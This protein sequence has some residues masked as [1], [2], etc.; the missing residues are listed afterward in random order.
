MKKLFLLLITLLFTM[1]VY[2]QSGTI[3]LSNDAQ[4]AGRGGTSIGVFN[5]YELMMSNP[6]GLSFVKN[7]TLDLN[8]SVMRS[9]TY[10]KNTLNDT[11]GKTDYN[12]L[13]DLGYVHASKNNSKWA[14]GIGAFTQGGMGADFSLNNALYV[15]AQGNYVKQTYHSK[16][17]MMEFGP[18]VAYK[19]SNKFSVG[20]SAHLVYSMMEFR[21]P[22]GM[23]PAVMAGEAMPGM[24]FGQM[25]AASPAQGGFGYNEVIASANMNNLNVISWTG[26]IGFAYKPNEKWSF[27]LNFNLPTILNFKNGKASMDMTAQF[28]DAFG[29][30]VQ[31]YMAQNPGSTSSEAMAAV[32]S[33]FSAMGINLSEGV[34]G[35]YDLNLKMKMPLSIGYGMSYQASS[36]LN[37]ALDVIWTNWANAFDKME[38]TLSNGTNSNINTMLGSSGFTYNFPLNWKNTV[39]VKFG[40]EYQFTHRFALRAGYDYNNNP[41]PASTLFPIFPAIVENHVTFGG[42]YLI[43]KRFT[44]NAAV[45]GALFNKQTATDPSAIQSEF[46]GSTSGLKTMIGHISFSYKL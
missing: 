22:F 33:E 34:A 26:K 6:A 28:N 39:T 10:F 27:G 35:T 7:S 4:S 32:A 45:E 1:G 31:G 41:V 12:P 40:A 16:F 37:L 21:M 9:Q 19:L 2:A 36:K 46:S 44:I 25:F 3:M 11:Y 30:A 8:L 38:M 29:K 15:D 43:G 24:T 42:S 17:A 18:S 14:W 23:N 5:S 20:I 13:P